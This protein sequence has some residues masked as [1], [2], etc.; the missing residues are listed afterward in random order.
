MEI[1]EINM[2]CYHSKD[3]II[4]IGHSGLLFEEEKLWITV[5]Q[6]PT[7]VQ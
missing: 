4:L 1:N 2:A 6:A 5:S 7:D 3:P